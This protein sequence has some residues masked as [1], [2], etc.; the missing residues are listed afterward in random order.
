MYAPGSPAFATQTAKLKPDVGRSRGKARYEQ[1]LF[2]LAI[3][4]SVGVLVGFVAAVCLIIPE[5]D[6]LAV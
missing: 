1:V 4:L 5:S 2:G 3:G 6:F